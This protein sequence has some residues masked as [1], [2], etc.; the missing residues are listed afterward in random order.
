MQLGTWQFQVHVETS[1]QET[2]ATLHTLDIRDIWFVS[3]NRNH[4]IKVRRRPQVACCL[5]AGLDVDPGVL[6]RRWIIYLWSL[7]TT[8]EIVHIYILHVVFVA[9]RSALRCPRLHH[10]SQLPAMVCVTSG[11]LQNHMK[12]SLHESRAPTAGGD[13]QSARTAGC[14]GAAGEPGEESRIQATRGGKLKHAFTCRWSVEQDTRSRGTAVTSERSEQ[15]RRWQ[16][17]FTPRGD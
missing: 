6:C 5:R 4:P 2:P 15:Q 13:T 3:E 14:Q 16:Q 10:Y 12:S 1:L 7:I 9:S 11:P 8:R 17:H